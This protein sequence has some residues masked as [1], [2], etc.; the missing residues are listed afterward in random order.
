MRMLRS[1]LKKRL[2]AAVVLIA[3]YS[4]RPTADGAEAIGKIA[5]PSGFRAETVYKVPLDK[6]GSWVSLTADDRGRLIA[7]DQHGALYRITPAPIGAPPAQTKVE[8]MDVAVGMAQGLLFH[9]GRLYVVQNGGSGAFGAG[10]YRL[11]DTNRDD[12]FDRI[13]QL[14]IFNGEGEHGPHAVVLGP[15]G[16]SLYF[17]CGN[18]TRLSLFSRSLVPTRWAE[19]QLLPCITDPNGHA[20]NIRAP[21]G[22][23][24]RTDLDGNNME[25]FSVGFRNTYDLAFNADGELFTFDSDMEWDVG[26]PWYRPTRVC[27]VTSGADFGWRTGNANWPEYYLDSAPAA[28]DVGPGSPTGMTFGYGTKFPER[29][30]HALFAGDWS[31][32]IIYAFHLTPH[33]STYRGE[34]ERFAS[35]MPLAVTDMVVRPQ[36]GALYFTVGGRKSESGLYRIVYAGEGATAG[37][38]ANLSSTK[39]SAAASASPPVATPAAPQ[40][41]QAAAE[42]RKR[43]RALE[44]FHVGPSPGA[45]DMLWPHLSS[46]DRSLSTAARVALEHQPFTEWRQ[47]ALAEPDV[48]ARLLALAAFARVADSRQQAEWAASLAELK[49]PELDRNQRLMLLRTAA[50]GVLRLQPV[51]PATR[52]KLLTQLDAYFPTD[53]HYVDR[54]LANLLVKLRAPGVV[55]RLLAHLDA[56]TTQEEAIDLA[57]A[58]SAAAE[59]WTPTS[60]TRFLD[61]F[62][63]S[64]RLSGGY[65]FFGYIVAARDRFI[66]NIPFDERAAMVDRIARPLVERT[67]QIAVETRP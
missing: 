57:M 27:H 25:L 36:D 38:N 51:E 15:D 18:H 58:L 26:T 23:F 60:R 50:L 39:R 67:P 30:Q 54:D 45:V 17:T 8:R 10:L 14:R 6:E 35:A 61:W 21:G 5:L 9:K 56:V 49:F 1:A 66:A 28:I 3:C 65:S 20:T 32:G 62:D 7:S 29:Y 34:T 19:D 41:A 48:N 44:A 40:A 22:W 13:E 4:P 64:S 42:A 47:R 24:A 63:K 11:S 12:K 53:D 55:D 33:G 46:L 2:V 59:G 43:R 37:A 31:Y 16:D 52:Q